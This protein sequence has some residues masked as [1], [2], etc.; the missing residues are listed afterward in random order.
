MLEEIAGAF[1]NAMID[2]CKEP[3]GRGS[4]PEEQAYVLLFLNDPKASY[5]NGANVTVDGGF[6]DL[7]SLNGIYFDMSI[8][9][10]YDE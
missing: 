8:G 3:S 1:G 10:L 9:Q 6:L 4:S 7:N 2:P 5:V